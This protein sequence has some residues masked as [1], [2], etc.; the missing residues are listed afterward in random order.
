MNDLVL[1]NSILNSIITIRLLICS[2]LVRIMNLSA[3]L[4]V[5]CMLNGI[6]FAS[7]IHN[8][9]AETFIKDVRG[10]VKLVKHV[11]RSLKQQNCM[12]ITESNKLE[13]RFLLDILDNDIA[14]ITI[15]DFNDLSMETIKGIR[16]ADYR[17]NLLSVYIFIWPLLLT[18]SEM[19]MV[20]VIQMI[21]DID[22]S[23]E[24]AVISDISINGKQFLLNNPIYDVHVFIPNIS[25]EGFL[26]YSK[27]RFC[28]NGKNLITVANLWLFNKEF[29]V[30]TMK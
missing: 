13:S 27:C 15:V 12:L 29:L 24:I 8:Q 26:M 25:G 3:L 20:K 4:E 1:F 23:A 21:K 11:V 28:D 7:F 30:K 16:S 6:V 5:F 19:E 18:R 2:F 17:C 9:T 14:A 10:I 22:Y